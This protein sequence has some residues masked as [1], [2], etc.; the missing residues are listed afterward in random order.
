MESQKQRL[1]PSEFAEFVSLVLGKRDNLSD[2][3]LVWFGKR[4]LP[5]PIAADLLNV[6]KQT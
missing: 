4:M 3:L 6:P 2:E 5:N 1:L